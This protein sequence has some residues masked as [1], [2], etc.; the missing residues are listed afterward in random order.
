MSKPHK[1]Q[2]IAITLDDDSVAIMHFVLDPVVLPGTWLPGMGFEPRTEQRVER[3]ATDEAIQYE[4]D[5]TVFDGAQPVRWERIGKADI[6]AD[7]RYRS[8]WKGRKLG[9]GPLFIMHDMPRARAV[10]RAMLREQR[11]PM[12]AAL[13]VDYQRADEDGDQPRKRE[14]AARKR[15][16]R[17]APADPRIEAANSIAELDAIA[18]P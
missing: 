15:A 7:R 4:I 10:K 5:K 17:D 18:L 9:D 1:T 3:A 6:P 13:D 11:A 2:E 14:I 12:L 16:L 8:A